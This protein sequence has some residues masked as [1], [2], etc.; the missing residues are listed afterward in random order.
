MV[1]EKNTKKRYEIMI[2]IF[3]IISI[4]GT[5]YTYLNPNIFVV[6]LFPII[7]V[8]V[9][10]L[11]WCVVARFFL[12]K[13]KE[14]L[15]SKSFAKPVRLAMFPPV[16]I[17]SLLLLLSMPNPPNSDMVLTEDSLAIIAFAFIIFVLPLAVLLVVVFGAMAFA[18]SINHMQSTP[19]DESVKYR[20]G[21]LFFTIIV[22]ILILI[23]FIVFAY[24]L[25][26]G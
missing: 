16:S 10:I 6:I 4:L 13:D 17:L 24:S 12:Y 18:A 1:K 19:L 23:V 14:R 7:S 9:A 8:C 11:V 20:K 21:P 15:L 22:N 25:V 5:V 26:A 2:I 3:S